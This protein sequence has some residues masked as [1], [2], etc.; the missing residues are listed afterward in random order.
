MVIISSL[1]GRGGG[2]FI[3]DVTGQNTLVGA[4]VKSEHNK[5]IRILEVECKTLITNQDWLIHPKK[6]NVKHLDA[7][8]NLTIVRA[9]ENEGIGNY[10]IS[11]FYIDINDEVKFDQEI[12]ELEADKANIAFPAPVAGKVVDIYVSLG[13]TIK[14]GDA[15]LAIDKQDNVS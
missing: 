15:I 7:Q 1:L 8:E 5:W 14:P 4:V 12:F 2:S 11:Y 3:F 10:L 6:L 9:P 13:D